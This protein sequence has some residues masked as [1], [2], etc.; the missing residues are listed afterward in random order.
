M[1]S[2]DDLFSFKD[3]FQNNVL[4]V[5][6]VSHETVSTVALRVHA[7]RYGQ[8]SSTNFNGFRGTVGFNQF[9]DEVKFDDCFQPVRFGNTLRF[10]QMLYSIPNQRQR[11]GEEQ[12]N[13]K[14]RCM[15]CLNVSHFRTDIYAKKGVKFI[16]IEF[17]NS[18]DKLYV[19]NG[20]F[21]ELQSNALFHA[22]AVDGIFV[23][24][25]KSIEFHA[26]NLKRFQLAI[27]YFKNGAFQLKYCLEITEDGLSLRLSQQAEI[28]TVLTCGIISTDEIS[29]VSFRMHRN[30][31]GIDNDIVKD[32][33]YD[34][35]YDDAR[36]S[37]IDIRPFTNAIFNDNVDSSD[38]EL[39]IVT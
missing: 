27:A 8:I 4:V 28:D 23:M 17:K 30:S 10:N 29:V 5:G 33:E 26:T 21:Q 35:F 7:N 25:D 38:S 19:K 2:N 11:Q 16:S 31:F 12:L 9:L 34:S 18:K 1:A 14:L 15:K 3:K 37:Q 20:T 32:V 22:D 13:E 39:V 6:I 36:V 24:N